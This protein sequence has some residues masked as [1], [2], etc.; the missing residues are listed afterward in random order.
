MAQR[1]KIKK[2][3]L[4]KKFLSFKKGTHRW[5]GPIGVGLI[6]ILIL[7]SLFL[8]KN[9]LQLLKEKL[10]KNSYYLE[11]KLKLSKALLESNQFKAAE[12]ILKSTPLTEDIKTSQLWQEKHYSDPEDIRQLIKIWEEIIKDKPHYRDGYLQLTI[13]HYKIKE[14]EK[15]RG[16]LQKA[17]EIDPNFELSNKLK[18]II[19]P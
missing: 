2:F 9:N 8:P 3:F 13:L 11:N 10:L 6:F 7:L 19:F 12:V 14:K 18:E 15:A 1:I 5:I 16:N 4:S 17:L